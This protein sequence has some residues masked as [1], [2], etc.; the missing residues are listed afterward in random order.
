MPSLRLFIA[1]E[2]PS[3]I[4]PKIATIRDRLRTS[5]AHVRWEPDEKLHATLKFLGKTDERLLPEI[6]L[7]IRRVAL[8]DS[9]L[10][11][12]YKG[13]GCFPNRRAPRV[14][15]VGIEDLNG[16]LHSLQEKIQS[17]FIPLGFD[18]EEREFHAH[19]TLGRVKDNG[20]IHSLLRMM[21]STTFESQAAEIREVALIN[22]ELKPNGSVYTTLERIP[23]SK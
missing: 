11:L 13:V 8:T 22:S 19:V 4:I 15:W 2:T 18:R 12:R 9:P 3:S 21:E 6:V 23:L 5:D 7:Y 10:L 20:N 16:S 1:V 17:V 14:I